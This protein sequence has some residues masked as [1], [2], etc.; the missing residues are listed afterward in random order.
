MESQAFS[1]AK[2]QGPRAKI[3]Q[4]NLA[5]VLHG[6][7]GHEAIPVGDLAPDHL[8]HGVLHGHGVVVNLW[9]EEKTYK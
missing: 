5:P 1:Q 2:T 4:L 6:E 8:R 3:F 7:V 9:R